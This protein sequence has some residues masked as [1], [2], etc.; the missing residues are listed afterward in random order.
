MLTSWPNEFAASRNYCG[1]IKERRFVAYY[2]ANGG[3]GTRAAIQAG[4]SPRSARTNCVA[5]EAETTR[6]RGDQA[7]P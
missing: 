2:L 4:Y 1:A 5:L 6:C 3:H 7:G